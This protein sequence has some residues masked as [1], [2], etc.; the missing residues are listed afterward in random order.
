MTL[1]L[2][3]AVID[4]LVNHAVFSYQRATL[5]IARVQNPDGSVKQ[6]ANIQAN[7]TPTWLGAIGWLNWVT[8]LAAII[9][10]WQERWWYAV[11]YVALRLVASAFLPTFENRNSQRIYS[12][13]HK[14]QQ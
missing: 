6:L 11:V 10:L 13:Y 8:F 1:A 4:F 9:L 7:Y 12:K 3:M 5:L 14:T 2:L